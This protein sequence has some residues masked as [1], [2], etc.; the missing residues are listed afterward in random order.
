MFAN[1]GKYIK[2]ALENKCGT[3]FLQQQIKEMSPTIYGCDAVQFRVT[4]KDSRDAIRPKHV[5]G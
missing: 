5:Q 1:A 4:I 2:L 3:R